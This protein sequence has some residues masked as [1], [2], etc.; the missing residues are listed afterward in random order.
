MIALLAVPAL[1]SAGTITPKIVTSGT[2]TCALQNDGVLQCFGWNWVGQTSSTQ[3]L[4]THTPARTVVD[5]GAGAK[6]VDVAVGPYVTCALLETGVLKCFGSNEYG[7]I[8]RSPATD[9]PNPTPEAVDFGPGLKVLKVA[10]GQQ[11]TCAVLDNASVKCF[12]RN[13]W[14]NLGSTNNLGTITPN[15]VPVTV[16]L[17]PGDVPVDVTAGQDHT[18]VLLASG[19]VKC[20]GS[21]TYGQYGNG[22]SGNS[23]QATPTAVNL[24]PGRTATAVTAGNFHTCV[25]LDDASVACFGNNSYG[26]LGSTTNFETYNPNPTPIAV[27]LGVGVNVVQV[28]AMGWNTCVLTGAGEMKC[29][30]G[31]W[32][33]ETGAPPAPP[34]ASPIPTTIN[35][36]SRPLQISAGSGTNCALSEDGNARCLGA[37]NYEQQGSV[38]PASSTPR[39]VAGLVNMS[40]PAGPI[41][42]PDPVDPIAPP[43]G[44]AMI[45][46]KITKPKWKLSR[47]GSKI[48]ARATLVVTAPGMDAAHCVGRLQVSVPSSSA[49]GTRSA[50]TFALKYAGGRCTANAKRTL[51]LRVARRGARLKIFLKQAPLLRAK[52]FVSTT[53]LP[54]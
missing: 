26:Q 1:A 30:G 38:G 32:S 29:F 21:N 44:P 42:P 47:K 46:G 20:F 43:I 40:Y 33:G 6:A 23:P 45:D 12:G 13:Y 8:A 4:Q 34:S 53:K 49:M 37:N 9:L 10:A 28:S 18:C 16:D 24:P 25:L 39:I 41:T 22:A 31:N 7:E 3:N 52:S 17:A 54:G 50:P 14:G 48:T 15:V 19:G 2:H 36:P 5:L 51:P 27:N 11:H 35:L